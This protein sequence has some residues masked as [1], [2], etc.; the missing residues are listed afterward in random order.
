MQRFPVGYTNALTER[1][2]NRLSWKFRRFDVKVRFAGTNRLT[3]LGGNE[4]K[5]EIKEIL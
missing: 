5:K 1:L 4:D 3:I 2:S